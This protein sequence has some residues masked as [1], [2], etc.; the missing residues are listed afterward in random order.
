MQSRTIVALGLCLLVF[1]Q[2]G[3]MTAFAAV[4]PENVGGET[5]VIT[6][7]DS[8]GDPHERVVTPIDF[9]GQLFVA[10]NH[11]PRAWYHRALEHPEV[12]V[13]RGGASADYR[14]IPVSDEQRERLLDAPGFPL[15]GYVFTGFA[16]RQFLRLDPR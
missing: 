6:T 15:L 4:Q 12:R 16:P 13:T 1:M 9:E 3:C 14:A 7:T 8:A 10:A 2:S 11:W 5:I